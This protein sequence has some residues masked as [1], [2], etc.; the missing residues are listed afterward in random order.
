[1]GL[2][3]VADIPPTKSYSHTTPRTLNS[4]STKSAKSLSKKSNLFTK[5]NVKDYYI[6]GNREELTK[7]AT[8][9][10]D[11]G[12]LKSIL[13]EA[14]YLLWRASMSSPMKPN[15]DCSM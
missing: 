9:T 5:I 8:E 13:K 2:N 1:M 12:N 4:T 15:N 3:D 14:T 6:S 7:D 10:V 11:N